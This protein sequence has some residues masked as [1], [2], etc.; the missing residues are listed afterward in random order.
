MLGDTGQEP[1]TRGSGFGR[2]LAWIGAAGLLLGG[3]WLYAEQ[4][5]PAP[6][7]ADGAMAA[8][9]SAA[10]A[11]AEAAGQA[12]AAAGPGR[13]FA[14]G[15]SSPVVD[16]AK[17][18]SE[19]AA[20]Q[21]G[22]QLSNLKQISGPQVVVMTVPSL[23]GAKIENYSLRIANQWGIGDT[24]RN[25]GVLLLIAPTEKQ[26]RIEVGKGL[27]GVLTDAISKQIITGQMLP[28]FRKGN[29]EA[30]AQAGVDALVKLLS[31]NPTLPRKVAK[32]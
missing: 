1:I 24:G 2:V 12:K 9:Q 3:V 27:E 6:A 30:A 20:R 32:P 22:F 10:E 11:A 5:E 7:T 31:A 26:V 13:T 21:M 25:D 16:G 29:M 4:R 19:D 17:L 28:H 15:G 18:F 23:G 8:A 14:D